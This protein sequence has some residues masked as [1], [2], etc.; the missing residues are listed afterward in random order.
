[1]RI[2]CRVKTIRWLNGAILP[3]S[4]RFQFTAM[5]EGT[6]SQ[7]TV[8]ALGAESLAGASRA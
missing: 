8:K 5:V 3:R 2:T 1:M 6:C 4:L 7:I